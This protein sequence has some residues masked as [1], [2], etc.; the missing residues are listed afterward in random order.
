MRTGIRRPMLLLV[1]AALLGL[2]GLTLQACG[3]TL[4]DQ[5][6]P[7]NELEGL[8]SAAPPV[9]WVGASFAG[10]PL[11]EAG[12]DVGG[13]YVVQY[14][15]C[16]EGGQGTCVAPLRILSAPDNGFVPASSTA[17]DTRL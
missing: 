12:R 17:H 10:L 5:P 7:H 13:A 14:G 6:I 11:T 8:I 15:D 9:Y 3:N 1:S 2:A 4:Q 16:L